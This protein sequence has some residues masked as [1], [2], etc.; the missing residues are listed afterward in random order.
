MYE[1]LER[2]VSIAI[3]RIRDFR[4]LK[5]SFDGRGNFSLGIREQNVFPEISYDDIDALR[6]IDVTITTLQ[7]QMKKEGPYCEL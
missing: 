3:P 5:N 2:L 1:F 7:R 4:G 6:G